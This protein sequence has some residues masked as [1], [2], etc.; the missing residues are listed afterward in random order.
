MKTIITILAA[1]TITLSNAQEGI[2]A[3]IAQDVRLLIKG[4][5]IGNAAGTP[6]VTISFEMQGNQNNLGY[7]IVRPEMEIA[8]LQGGKY[9]RYTANVGYSFNQWIEKLTLTATIG[10]GFVDYNG[11]QSSFGNNLQM[12]YNIFEGISL[13]TDI[14]TAERKH[15]LSYESTNKVLG[16]A[17]R[18]SFFAGIKIKVFNKK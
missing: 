9:K 4:D 7:L 2:S 10:Y 5:E 17:W 14:Q 3:N 11:A 6:D 18:V 15:L 13:F 16:T 1:L 8:N 12:S